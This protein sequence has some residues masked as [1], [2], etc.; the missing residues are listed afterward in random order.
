[1]HVS[2]KGGLRGDVARSQD[3]R[4]ALRRIP[5]N[6]RVVGDDQDP[7]V[8]VKQ[9]VGKHLRNKSLSLA[10]KRDP[11]TFGADVA[12]CGDDRLQHAIAESLIGAEDVFV[13]V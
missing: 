3:H 5:N 6:A 1:M 10:M 12:A 9:W 13:R 4:S 2:H 7:N 11:K 8:F